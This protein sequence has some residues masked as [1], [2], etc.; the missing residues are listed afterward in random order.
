MEA[1]RRAREQQTK[2]IVLG[3]G[4]TFE[5]DDTDETADPLKDVSDS[6]DSILTD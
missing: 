1:E 2:N 6:L 5:D 3:L 4:D